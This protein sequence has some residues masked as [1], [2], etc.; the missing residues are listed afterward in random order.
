H[1]PEAAGAGV[2]AFVLGVLAMLHF[3]PAR[4]T[5]VVDTLG[6]TARAD[7]K[8]LWGV[9]PAW[10]LRALPKRLWV[11]LTRIKWGR[12]ILAIA[13]SPIPRAWATR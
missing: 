9:G 11:G 3:A 7:M 5:I 4:T 13:P 8:T 10:A 12:A 6:S 2:L 1:D